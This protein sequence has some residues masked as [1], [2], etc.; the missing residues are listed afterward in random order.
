MTNVKKHIQCPLLK[1]SI[2]D[3]THCCTEPFI[4]PYFA[5]CESGRL[6]VGSSSAQPEING[7]YTIEPDT[8]LDRPVYTQFILIMTPL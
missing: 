6:L 3:L 7:I 2:S 4:Y 5:G 1:T 8:Y